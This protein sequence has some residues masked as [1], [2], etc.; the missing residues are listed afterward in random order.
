[1]IADARRAGVVFLSLDGTLIPTDRIAT[2]VEVNGRPAHN[3]WFFGEHR[4]FGGTVQVLCDHT[5]FPLWDSDVR[6]GST[7]D[8]TA[9][10]D[11]VLPTLYPHTVRGLPVLADKG[12]TG[13]GAGIL[14]P[15]KTGP[16][17]RCT[18]TTAATTS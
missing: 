17:D 13:A 9:A 10:R 2:R 12:Y 3:L 7:V 11:L 14:V 1:M 6:P 8:L 18:S 4:V 16:R 15:Y 5:G